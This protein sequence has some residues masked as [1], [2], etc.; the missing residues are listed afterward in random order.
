M[1][2]CLLSIIQAEPLELCHAALVSESQQASGLQEALHA[3]QPVLYACRPA[4]KHS[5]VASLQ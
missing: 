2:L 1:L 3:L 4:V 5:G